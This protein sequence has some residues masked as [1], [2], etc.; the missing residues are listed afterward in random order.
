MKITEWSQKKYLL[1]ELYYFMDLSHFL[2]SKKNRL[3]LF[4]V[5]ITLLIK[6]NILVSKLYRIQNIFTHIYSIF[7]NH[8][9]FGVDFLWFCTVKALIERRCKIVGS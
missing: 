4:T 3:N 8:A 9:R 6:R 7:W 5:N 1:I 2:K